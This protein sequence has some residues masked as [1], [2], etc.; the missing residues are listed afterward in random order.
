[1]SLLPSL[2]KCTPATYLYKGPANAPGES[3][4]GA[5]PC[6]NPL[7]S[8]WYLAGFLP[9]LLEGT[10]AS[11]LDK[12]SCQKPWDP[13]GSLVDKPL[14]SALHKQDANV[15]GHAKVMGQKRHEGTWQCQAAG[16]DAHF[17]EP[18]DGMAV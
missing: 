15:R 12:P 17:C 2:L 9:S 14:A 1:M 10:P 16:A 18:R 5:S 13:R 3:A 11:S 6:P 7:S 8:S 4:L